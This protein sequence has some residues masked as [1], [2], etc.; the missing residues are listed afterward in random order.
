MSVNG[1][2]NHKVN[3]I[4]MNHSEYE[5]EEGEIDSNIGTP[6]PI[7]SHNFVIPNQNHT[8]TQPR[9]SQVSR[10]LIMIDDPIAIPL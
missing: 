8:N 9:E 2:N 10:Y 5:M 4:S 6:Q 7:Q 1:I 3:S